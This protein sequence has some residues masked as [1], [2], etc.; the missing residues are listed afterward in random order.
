M[1]MI[2]KIK[3]ILVKPLFFFEKIQEEKGVKKAF[4][5]FMVLA[6]FS[7]L[8]A[9]LVSL[10]MPVYSAGVL[11][12]LFGV[13]IP[14][15][16]LKSPTLILTGF[17]YILSLG[18]SF[19]VAGLLHVWILIFGG[20]ADY[21][22]SYQL[23]VYSNTPSYLFGWIPFLGF[24]AKIYSLILLIL[25]T[26]KMHDISRKRAILMYVIPMVIFSILGLIGIVLAMTALKALPLTEMAAQFQ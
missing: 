18:I 22:K 21:T 25:G 10:V 15:S 7:T 13:T 16:A 26:E 14:E 1:A 4:L 6:F 2:D 9:Y 12:K 8:L 24:F 3:D 20:K 11:E 17:Y 5:Y 23:F 19:L